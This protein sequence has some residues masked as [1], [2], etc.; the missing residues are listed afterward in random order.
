M[1][2]FKNKSGKMSTKLGLDRQKKLL[3]SLIIGAIALMP[4][5]TNSVYA[6]GNKKQNGLVLGQQ[7]LNHQLEQVLLSVFNN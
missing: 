5:A 4:I 7:V 1:S 2:S 6:S 3:K